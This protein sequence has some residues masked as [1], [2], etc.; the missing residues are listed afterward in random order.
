MDTSGA[1]PDRDSQEEE[2]AGEASSRAEAMVEAVRHA[3][4]RGW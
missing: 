4:Q 3:P 2:L 1:R